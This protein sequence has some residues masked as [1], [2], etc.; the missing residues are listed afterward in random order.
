MGGGG[1]SPLV[2][3]AKCI[4]SQYWRVIVYLNFEGYRS[5][6]VPV[7]LLTHT[8]F[9]PRVLVAQSFLRWQPLSL[10]FCFFLCVLSTDNKDRTQ[11]WVW[12]S[13][14]SWPVNA[15][16]ALLWPAQAQ[17]H[18]AGYWTRQLPGWWLP[19]MPSST[20]CHAT[21]I[22]QFQ[23]YP[24]WFVPCGKRQVPPQQPHPHNTTRHCSRPHGDSLLP[25]PFPPIV[26]RP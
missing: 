24:A 18:H 23:P 2:S 12:F 8:V 14:I 6:T 7:L 25:Q 4:L 22:S 11:W 19:F 15:F 3:C 16:K 1:G 10:T 20:C 26:S 13:G 9:V 17:P 5:H 21:V